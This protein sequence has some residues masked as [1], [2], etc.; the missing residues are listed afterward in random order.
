MRIIH[1]KTCNCFRIKYFNLNNDS[2]GLTE[3]EIE[4]FKETINYYFKFLL[5]DKCL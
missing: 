5:E 2:Y 4:L 3:K 1:K